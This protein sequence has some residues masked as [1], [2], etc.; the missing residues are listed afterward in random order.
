MKLIAQQPD[1]DETKTEVEPTQ[2]AT[3]YDMEALAADDD[4]AG[5]SW[6]FRLWVRV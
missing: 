4:R 5:R 2:A 3:V 1:I 6:L